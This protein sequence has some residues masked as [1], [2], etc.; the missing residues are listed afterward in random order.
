M[1]VNRDTM[2]RQYKPRQAAQPRKTHTQEDLQHALTAVGNGMT[3]RKA[4]K[5]F[6]I[7]R[8]VLNR[9][10]KCDGQVL[11]CIV[12]LDKY[13]AP[14]YAVLYGAIFSLYYNFHNVF[15]I[16]FLSAGTESKVQLS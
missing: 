8:S 3:Y 12:L 14:R 9:H 2:P 6:G 10:A 5:R 11:Y 13:Y 16:K 4:E 1:G 15:Y 7:A